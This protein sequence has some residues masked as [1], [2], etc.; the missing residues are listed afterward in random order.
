MK[1][2]V[3]AKF[4]IVF[5]VLVVAFYLQQYRFLSFG[6]VNPNLI[7]IG[8]SLLVFKVADARFLGMLVLATVAAAALLTPYWVLQL[9]TVAALIMGFYFLKE[10]LTGNHALDFLIVILAGT[11]LFY[12]VTNI[13]HLSLVPVGLIFKEVLYNLLLGAAAWFTLSSEYLVDRIKA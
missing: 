11:V 4:L 2:S 12:M 13:F 1:L 3:N 10:V 7:L 6:G 5:L 8:F 9:V